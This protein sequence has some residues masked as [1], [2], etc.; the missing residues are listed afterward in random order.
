MRYKF[1]TTSE[2]AWDAMIEDIGSAR[3]F[4]FLEMYIFIDNTDRHRFFEILAK[5]ARE[6]IKVKVI[7]DSFGSK[8]LS[9]ETITKLKIAGVELLFFSY[10][11]RR[12]HKKILVVDGKVAFLGG[13]N[14]H[15]L[16]QKWNDLQVRFTGTM[17]KSVTH[18]FAK[19]YQ[20]CGG[21][22]PEVL[23]HS[24]KENIFRKTKLWFL[25][26]QR[27]GRRSLIKTHYMDRLKN[28]K[29]NIVIVSPY[30]AP[31][32]WLFGALHQAVLRGVS[33]EVILPQHTDHFIFD[34]VNYFYISKFHQ[35]GIKFYLQR[36]MNHSKAML[37][38]GREGMVGSQNIDPF[39]FEYNLEAG[40]FFRD[41]RMVGDLEKIV[42][43]WKKN[44]VTFT[45]SMYKR[46]WFDYLLAPVIRIF[47][48]VI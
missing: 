11:L 27:I 22:D 39:S 3:K 48:S 18:S 15:K 33:V 23:A 19:S 45:P 29:E 12:T 37:I 36:E 2:S 35:T 28:A 31:H 32:R 38:D 21:K 7:V 41:E 46:T 4:I 26:H 6:G 10:W 8:E 34:R 1:Y 25:E 47:Q 20:M 16:F 30:F 40:I 17:V 42:D 44:S 5:K 13:V 9:Q 43:E 24:N 14:I